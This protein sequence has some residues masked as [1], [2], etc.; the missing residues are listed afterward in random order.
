MDKETT[1]RGKVARLAE[2]QKTMID[3]IDISASCTEYSLDK[4]Y[5]RMLC[6]IIIM[7]MPSRIISNYQ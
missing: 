6:Y 2:A 5:T 4:D 1:P 7:A 3:I